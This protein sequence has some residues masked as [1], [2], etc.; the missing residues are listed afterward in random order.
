[1]FASY[2]QTL[3]ESDQSALTDLVDTI[4]GMLPIDAIYADM[5]GDKVS[6]EQRPAY[7]LEELGDLAGRLLDAAGR[8]PTARANLLSQ[9]SLLEPFSFYPEE[10]ISIVQ[11]LTNEH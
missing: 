8:E 2:L 7:T 9:L 6:L 10:S 1:V 3:D 5:A 4:E 11:R